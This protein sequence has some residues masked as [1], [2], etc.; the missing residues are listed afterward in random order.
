MSSPKSFLVRQQ[1]EG[2][3]AHSIARVA[4]V[5]NNAR[6]T[7][8]KRVSR[9]IKAHQRIIETM[10]KTMKPIQG[11]ITCLAVDSIKT[12]ETLAYKSCGQIETETYTDGYTMLILDCLHSTNKGQAP[13]LVE[14]LAQTSVSENEKTGPGSPS[15]P[16]SEEDKV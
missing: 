2:G 7:T 12:A 13:N 9:E 10:A 5:Y 11:V 4:K 3:S 15:A 14:L 1:R 8:A 6:L 16:Q